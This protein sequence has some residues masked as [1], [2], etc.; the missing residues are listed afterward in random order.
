MNRYSQHRPAQT[1]TDY[2]MIAINP[3]L[4]MVM[5]GAIAMFA[6][7]A[8]YRGEYDFRLKWVLAMIVL[9]T[10]SIARLT[11]EQG[12]GYAS[13]YG[14]AFAAAAFL[15]LNFFVAVPSVYWF[16]PSFVF[17]AVLLG[18]IWWASHKLTWDCTVIDDA[19]DASGRGLLEVTGLEQLPAWGDAAIQSVPPIHSV[20]SQIDLPRIGE[21]LLSWLKRRI[22]FWFDRNS[23]KKAH[24]PGVW[25][26]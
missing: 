18:V 3:A 9:G 23:I 8:F 13:L 6:A 12:Y 5:V 4:I 7:E 25:V 22:A 19:E 15:G 10:V 1:L 16:L 17:N 14:M 24:T 2:V 20:V 26:I 11:I 21:R